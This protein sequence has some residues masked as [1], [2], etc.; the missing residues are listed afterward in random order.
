MKLASLSL[1][2][3][4]GLAA[5]AF[6]GGV[7]AHLECTP[8]A[9]TM[10]KAKQKIALDHDIACSIVVDSG[11]VPADAKATID[12]KVVSPIGA[13]KGHLKDATSPDAKR[14]TAPAFKAG[15]DFLPCGGLQF[16]AAIAQGDKTLWSGSLA[17][18]S[19]CAAVKPIKGTLNCAAD[20]AAGYVSYPGNGDTMKPE[21]PDGITCTVVGPEGNTDAHLAVIAIHGDKEPASINLMSVPQGAKAPLAFNQFIG[22]SVPKCKSFVVDAAIL[23][24]TAASM[25]T[26][27]LAIAQVCKKTK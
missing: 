15:G 1:L 3:L 6:A 23:D 2:A 8:D 17:V 20:S 10:L 18:S 13:V 25:W 22:A 12:A 9:G 14:F 4:V 11:T 26:G 21:L 24:K 7:K 5:P 16:D 19:K 27:K